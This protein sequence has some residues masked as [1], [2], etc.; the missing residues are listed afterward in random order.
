VQ[1]RPSSS[2]WRSTFRILSQ[3][4]RQDS[5]GIVAAIAVAGELD[6]LCPGQDVYAGAVERRAKRVRV[7]RLAPLAICLRMAFGAILALG[8]APGWTKSLP[9]TEGVSG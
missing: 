8:K 3:S 1:V 6:A 7:Q 2:K 4:A 9:T 5:N